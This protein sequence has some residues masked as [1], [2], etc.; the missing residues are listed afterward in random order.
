MK[1]LTLMILM[2]TLLLPVGSIPSFAQSTEQEIQELK[3]MVEQN[4]KQNDELMRRIEQLE[5]EKAA[6]QTKMDKFITDQ[7]DKDLKYDGLM[8]FF[9][10]I[11][12]GFY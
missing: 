11:D 5:S 7:E 2:L 12:L 3:Q 4:S 10:A 6:T 1:K 8:T 9:D